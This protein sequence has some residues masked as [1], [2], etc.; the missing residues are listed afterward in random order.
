MPT[1]KALSHLIP[2]HSLHILLPVDL[3][4]WQRLVDV[5]EPNPSPV[6]NNPSS[7][8]LFSSRKLLVFANV[9]ESENQSKKRH[10]NTHSGV[11]GTPRRVVGIVADCRASVH[12]KALLPTR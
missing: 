4:S 2:A 8:R 1:V 3:T 5:T 11:S 9:N 7:A 10:H 6:A 12:A